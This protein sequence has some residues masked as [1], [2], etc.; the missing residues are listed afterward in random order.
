MFFPE[1]L[2]GVWY[3]RY[4]FEITFNRW[5]ASPVEEINYINNAN[6]IVEGE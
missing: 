5:W 2:N 6:I 3:Q 4:D 1:Q